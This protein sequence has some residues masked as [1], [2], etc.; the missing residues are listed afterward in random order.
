MHLSCKQPLKVGVWGSVHVA[1]TVNN[2]QSSQLKLN[3]L[4]IN[5]APPSLQPPVQFLLSAI[6]EDKCEG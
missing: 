5:D 1:G 6:E 2:K 4:V 3:E